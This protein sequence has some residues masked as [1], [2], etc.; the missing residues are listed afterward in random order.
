MKK[1]SMKSLYRVTDKET[2]K[3]TIKSKYAGIFFKNGYAYA[4]NAFILIKTKMDYPSEFEGMNVNRDGSL[5]PDYHTPFE[6]VITKTKEAGRW[7]ITI[8][9]SKV[10]SLDSIA[11][12]N[13]KEG[14]L[15]YAEIDGNSYVPKLL[16]TFLSVTGETDFFSSTIKPMPCIWA[17]TET[18]TAILASTLVKPGEYDCAKYINVTV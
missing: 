17:E 2:K 15:T 1:M 10:K 8:S 6:A 18:T 14:L 11:A 9:Q 7:P 4:T 12:N 13:K 16:K 3:Q 5:N